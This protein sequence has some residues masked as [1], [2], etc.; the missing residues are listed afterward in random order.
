MINLLMAYIFPNSMYRV[1]SLP[2]RSVCQLQ[3]AALQIFLLESY[4]LLILQYT[5]FTNTSNPTSA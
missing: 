4:Y 1:S 3:N 2:P 5:I